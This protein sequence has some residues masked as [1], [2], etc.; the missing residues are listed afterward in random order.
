MIPRRVVV[1]LEVVSAL[2]LEVLRRPG[3]WASCEVTVAQ[4]Q[5]NVIRGEIPKKPAR[6]VARKGR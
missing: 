3:T 5:V 2:S 6:A 4:V 1:E